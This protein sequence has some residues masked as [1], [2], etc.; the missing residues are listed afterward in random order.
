[1]AEWV[2]ALA[3]AGDRTVSRPGSNPATVTSLRNFGNSVY[4]ALPVSF[5]GDTKS[6]RSLLSGVYARGSKRSHQ[7]ALE[8]VTVVDS[9][10]HSKLPDPQSAI[11][12]RKT[13]PCTCIG[14]RRRS[15]AR[16][17]APTEASLRLH[18]RS[19]YLNLALEVFM[20]S[21]TS[22]CLGLL[23][24]WGQVQLVKYSNTS[25]TRNQVHVQ[26]QLLCIFTNQVPGTQVHQVLTHQVQVQVRVRTSVGLYIREIPGR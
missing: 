8:C 21:N 19:K 24:G 1:M 26:V 13:L 3:W 2:R 22:P 18:W 15:L 14:R 4:R 25:S 7:S 17:S 5:G 23:Q 20:S 12:R 6:R 10:T 9:T 16:M 11:M